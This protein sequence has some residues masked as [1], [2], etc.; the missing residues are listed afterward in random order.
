MLTTARDVFITVG[1]WHATVVRRKLP[2]ILW[3]GCHWLELSI[4]DNAN[5]PFLF[6]FRWH[7]IVHLLLQDSKFDIVKTS[8]TDQTSDYLLSS[9]VSSCDQDWEM[10]S[11]RSW[12]VY[13][14]IMEQWASY[15]DSSLAPH[16]K[17][18]MTRLQDRQGSFSE[19]VWQWS[20]LVQW[21]D[22]DSSS[23]AHLTCRVMDTACYS[24]SRVEF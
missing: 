8:S 17:R 19:L 9:L 3:R 1:R 5:G 16:W 14:F 4:F 10:L 6:K 13:E 15:V 12:R 11:N 24:T 18:G 2:V 20:G 7:F 21:G 23:V 22:V